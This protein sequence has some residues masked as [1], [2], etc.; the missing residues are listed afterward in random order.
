[1]ECRLPNNKKVIPFRQP[2]TWRFY[3]WVDAT[4]SNPISDW[5]AGESDAVRFMFDSVLKDAMK[6]RNH[7]EWPCFRHKMNKEL[8]VEGV[9][10]LGFKADGRQYRLLVKF[11]GV[12]RMVILCGC[13][14]KE[15]RWTP[16]G[17]LKSALVRAR[18]LTRKEAKLH[19]RKIQDDF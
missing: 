17:A 13:Y 6:R 1:L 2:N 7:L 15:N 5:L 3:D 12:L 9:C 4:G 11:D 8:G 10:E 14:H 19:E 16:E 18:T